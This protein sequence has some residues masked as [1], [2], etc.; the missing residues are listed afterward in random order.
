[1][2]G[3][4][5]HPSKSYKQLEARKSQEATYLIIFD[6]VDDPEILDDWLP[7]EESGSVLITSRDPLAKTHMYTDNSGIILPPLDDDEAID[8]ILRTTR[9]EGEIEER[10]SGQAIVQ[11]LG[12]LPL[13]ITQM[14]GWIARN[15]LSFSEFLD[16]Y[17]KESAHERL[18]KLQLGPRKSRPQCDHTIASVW[19]LKG[20]EE[21]AASLLGV[22]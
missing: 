6:N 20:L 9:R 2:L 22:L 3:L 14:P 4:L 15:D 18:F 10:S 1:V 12:G 16:T 8:L 5:A 21:S 13:A 7:A 17:D 19:A 11:T